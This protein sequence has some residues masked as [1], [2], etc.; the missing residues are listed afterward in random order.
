[1]FL[2]VDL[3]HSADDV[4]AILRRPERWL[5]VAEPTTDPAAP[6][7]F[8]ARLPTSRHDGVLTVTVVATD[9][10]GITLDVTADDAALGTL[11]CE[12]VAVPRSHDRCTLDLLG[13]VSAPGSAILHPVRTGRTHQLAGA[14]IDHAATTIR[15]QLEASPDG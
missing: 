15:R 7:R 2:Q 3:A 12:L 8:L 13:E 1:M 10:S 4:A 6:G 14:L 9:S 11:T 5:P